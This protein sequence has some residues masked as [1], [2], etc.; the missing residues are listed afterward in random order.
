[1]ICRAKHKSLKFIG[2]KGHSVL[3]NAIEGIYRMPPAN[4]IAVSAQHRKS[5][6]K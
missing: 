6:K 2:F 3:Q 4:N 1:M 5:E